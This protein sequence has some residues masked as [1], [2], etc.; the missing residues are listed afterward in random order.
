MQSHPVVRLLAA[1]KLTEKE[2]AIFIAAAAAVAATVAAAAVAG[3]SQRCVFRAG[4]VAPTR[5]DK[6]WR[7]ICYGV[8]GSS[9]SRPSAADPLR[10]P[11]EM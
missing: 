9:F 1:I 10:A 6:R 5:P 11:G 2:V 3:P 8:S 7:S 4:E